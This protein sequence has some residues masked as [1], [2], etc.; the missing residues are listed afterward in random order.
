[1]I[2]LSSTS[3]KSFCAGGDVTRLFER[4]DIS[5]TIVIIRYHFGN[6]YVLDFEIH[7]YPKPIICW[8]N[9]IIMGGGMGLFSVVIE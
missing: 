5:K 9:G 6:E 1:M 8:G 4:F 2:F 3:E 7:N